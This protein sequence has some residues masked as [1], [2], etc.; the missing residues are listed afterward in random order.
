R[1]EPSRACAPPHS[2]GGPER[3]PHP[4]LRHSAHP[5]PQPEPSRCYPY[6]RDGSMLDAEPTRGPLHLPRSIR[7]SPR[8]NE[9]LAS[10][11]FN[12]LTSSSIALLRVAAGGL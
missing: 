9:L 10:W 6:D 1:T 3:S 11:R 7:P 4:Q 5:T 2:R 12:G 8:W